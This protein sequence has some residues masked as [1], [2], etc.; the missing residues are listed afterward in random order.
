MLTQITQISCHDVTSLLLVFEVPPVSF[1]W[2]IATVGH[3]LIKSRLNSMDSRQ[4]K[5]KNTIIMK[6]YIF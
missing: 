2:V 4:L 3:G 5:E 6:I 1:G